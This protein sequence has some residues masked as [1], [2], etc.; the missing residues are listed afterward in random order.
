[1]SHTP[2]M[3]IKTSLKVRVENNCVIL[4]SAAP[5]AEDMKI[6]M[7]RTNYVILKDSF[8]LLIM[9]LIFS[10]CKP[11]EPVYSKLISECLEQSRSNYL[12]TGRISLFENPVR[13]CLD[14][15][16]DN[17]KITDLLFVDINGDTIR[18]NDIEKPLY[19]QTFSRTAGQ[20]FREL[21]FLNKI[22][23]QYKGNVEFILLV[24]RNPCENA[25]QWKASP[26]ECNPK[27]NDNLR[28]VYF[29]DD[30]AI[31][32]KPGYGQLIHGIRNTEYPTCYYLNKDK[33]IFRITTIED[34]LIESNKL[35]AANE[36][37][38][39]DELSEKSFEN[40]VP[41]IFEEFVDQNR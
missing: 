6:A 37:L 7:V 12:S 27:F 8:A 11:E 38:T 30:E 21:K 32:L 35:Y 26:D 16:L 2:I 40:R 20:C 17:Q 25:F 33:T 39:D 31:D 29:E 10:S 13:K 41:K 5:Q 1:M 22:A 34:V 36:L 24:N 15:K 14:E 19:I 9:L 4:V 3:N 23:E 28:I 18:I